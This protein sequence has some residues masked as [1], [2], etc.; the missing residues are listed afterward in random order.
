[1]LP[2]PVHVATEK[3]PM[4]M[5]FAPAQTLFFCSATSAPSHPSSLKDLWQRSHV[6]PSRVIAIITSTRLAETVCPAEARFLALWTIPGY[7]LCPRVSPVNHL[8]CCGPDMTFQKSDRGR[9]LAE[10]LE[11]L[12]V[13]A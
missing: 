1:M 12:Q 11:R 6:D 9:H 13:L 4:K 3:Y 2:D 5:T 7:T 10:R 8:I